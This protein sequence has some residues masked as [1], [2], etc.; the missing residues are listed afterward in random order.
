MFQHLA[1]RFRHAIVKAGECYATIG[2]VQ[3]GDDFGQ[4][5]DGVLR[6]APEQAGMKIAI[7]RFDREF[8]I[9]HA[10]Q[11]RG[12]L[13]RVAVPHRGVANERDIG[14]KRVFFGFHK[15]GEMF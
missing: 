6:S 11:A 7:R 12:D 4:H 14:F 3:I 1:R 5:A 8:F 13:R 15:C 10:A 9:D 2:I